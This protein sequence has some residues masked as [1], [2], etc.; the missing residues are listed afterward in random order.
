MCHRVL[1]S[2]CWWLCS[3]WFKMLLMPV[4]SPTFPAAVTPVAELAD[5]DV[6]ASTT[7]QRCMLNWCMAFKWVKED[8]RTKAATHYE[9]R[10][11]PKPHN[12]DIKTSFVN[13]SFNRLN[14]IQTPPDLPCCVQQRSVGLLRSNK[15]GLID[16]AP[17]WIRKIYPTLWLAVCYTHFQSRFCGLL[18]WLLGKKNIV[19]SDRFSFNFLFLMFQIVEDTEG[20][21]KEKGDIQWYLSQ[22]GYNSF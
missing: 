13:N 22:G 18:P 17:P 19:F 10:F 14:H 15:N 3:Q 7:L 16:V 20:R 4:A 12:L 2:H 21:L 11:S 1:T 9:K 6:S 5:E 8:P